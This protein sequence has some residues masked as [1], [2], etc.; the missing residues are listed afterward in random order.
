MAAVLPAWSEGRTL[1]QPKEKYAM[2]DPPATDEND[3]SSTDSAQASQTPLTD[4]E[5]EA[6]Y[7]EQIRRM[8]CVGCGETEH[9]Y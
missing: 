5:L 6:R 4:A 8:S 3:A 7:A 2:A 9:I 1:R